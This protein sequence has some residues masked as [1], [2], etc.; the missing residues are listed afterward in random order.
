MLEEIAPITRV[1]LIANPKN[2]FDYF[3]GAAEP[4]ARSLSIELVPSRFE[5][6]AEIGWTLMTSGGLGDSLRDEGIGD[7]TLGRCWFS[8]LLA[9][10]SWR[11]AVATML[12]LGLAAM[13]AA[14]AG[15]NGRWQMHN[16][17]RSSKSKSMIPVGSFAIIAYPT[18]QVPK[19]RQL[20]QICARLWSR[21]K[22]DP[23]PRSSRGFGQFWLQCYRSA[24]SQGQIGLFA[25]FRRLAT[26]LAHRTFLR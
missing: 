3:V 13:Q 21:H 22:L 5:N 26:L 8:D 11:I 16:Q 2:I 10:A 6:A 24:S 25:S 4:V 14:L 17:P 23:T 15:N 1:A 12:A 7:N 20:R 18:A 19:V 9:W